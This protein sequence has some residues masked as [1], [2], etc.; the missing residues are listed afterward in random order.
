M[1]EQYKAM[2]DELRGQCEAE[3]RGCLTGGEE[4]KPANIPGGYKTFFLPMPMKGTVY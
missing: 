4:E 1:K 3:E 2:R